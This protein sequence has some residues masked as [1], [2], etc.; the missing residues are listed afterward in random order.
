[1][2]VALLS[3]AKAADYPERPI[4]MVIP[5]EAGS[6]TDILGRVI[7][8]LAEKELGV[9]L[10][11][12]NKPGGTGATGYTYVK[13]SRP[14]G[15]V[16]GLANSTIASHKIFGNLPFDYHDVEVIL[17]FQTSP[18]IL[19]VPANS[20]YKTLEDVIADARERPGQIIYAT[21]SG[22]VLSGTRDFC[23][24]AG[25]QFKILPFGGGGQQ[26]AIQASGGHADISFTNILEA[27]APIEAGLLRPLA[28]YGKKRIEFLPDVPIFEELGYPVRCPVIRGLIAPPGVPKEKL[29][30][31]NA[32]F[33]K[34]VADPRY[35]DFVRNS[36]GSPMDASFADAVT[37]LDEQRKA[38]IL[39]ASQENG[40]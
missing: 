4:E 27:R 17:I 5:F 12:N 16:L 21:T 30:I 34:A 18:S 40:L 22:N 29:E 20:K 25:I 9:K 35:R 15:Y 13:N 19:C 32:A 8:E 31:I 23:H 11:I 26:P 10:V 2:A 33:R 38:F 36:A 14:D 28:V 3:P 37:L 1:M 6:A 39:V 7:S 24:H